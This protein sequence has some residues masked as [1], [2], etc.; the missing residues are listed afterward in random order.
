MAE[1]DIVI[2][3]CGP[4]AAEFVTP[5][6]R[7]AAEQADVLVGAPRLLALFATA[8][9]ER[10]AADAKIDDLL[11]R[12]NATTQAGRCV[13]VLVSGDPGVFSL[14]RNIVLRFGAGRCRIVPGIS[15]VQVAFAR[16]GLDWLNARVVSAHGRQP[17]ATAEEL[18]ACDRAAILIGTRAGQAW[19]AGVAA[20][21]E[22]TH[23]IFLCEN[24][25]LH[26]ERVARVSAAELAGA[27]AAS[28][29]IVLLVRKELL[30]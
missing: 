18:A 4:G 12:I 20:V 5:A 8:G 23:A 24:L 3:G 17:E 10:I 2:A 28:L 14:A 29:A 16:V 11:D 1:A 6:T 13:T 27:N 22:S 25:T 15:S 30:S 19:S 26:D 7:A 21:A 9:R